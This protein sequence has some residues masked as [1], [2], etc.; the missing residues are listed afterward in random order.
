MARLNASYNIFCFSS[1]FV[2]LTQQICCLLI[3]FITT[4]ST[5]VIQEPS[6]HFGFE[7]RLV[8]IQSCYE[9]QFKT[10]LHTY[11][12]TT[13]QVHYSKE[14]TPSKSIQECI[15]RKRNIPPSKVCKF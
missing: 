7:N 13:L 3:V 8:I 2:C 14:N 4:P 11:F 12:V 15:L 1:V 9:Y 10:L 5:S 6:E